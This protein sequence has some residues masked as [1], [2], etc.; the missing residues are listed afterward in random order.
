MNR[1]HA[2]FE[3]VNIFYHLNSYRE[4]LDSLGFGDL[5]DYQLKVDAHGMDG[6]DQSAYSPLQDVLA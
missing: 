6:A 3:E 2:G 1:N 4:F 5:A